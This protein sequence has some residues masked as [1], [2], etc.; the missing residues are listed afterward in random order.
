MPVTGGQTG[1]ERSPY[2]PLMCDGHNWAADFFCL[3]WTFKLSTVKEINLFLPACVSLIFL[4]SAFCLPFLFMTLSPLFQCLCRLS[5]VLSPP[6]LVSPSLPPFIRRAGSGVT[7]YFE[8]A[9][10]VVW[11]LP[12]GLPCCIII[13]EIAGTQQP[14]AASTTTTTSS[15]AL[16]HIDWAKFKPSSC[17]SG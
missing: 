3:C 7:N 12:S 4:S 14:L 13:R 1:G 16:G 8:R 17:L 9:E 2:L 10:K 5:H 15:P 6:P 11:A